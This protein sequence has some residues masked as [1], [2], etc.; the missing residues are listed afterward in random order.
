[1]DLDKNYINSLMLEVYAIVEESKI[2]DINTAINI[3]KDKQIRELI[4]LER[5]AFLKFLSIKYKDKN[6][7]EEINNAKTKN[8]RKKIAEKY[9]KDYA[10]WEKRSSSLRFKIGM[11]LST[12]TFMIVGA[13]NN[14]VGLVAILFFCNELQVIFHKEKMTMYDD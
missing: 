13:T 14:L 11:G 2:P 1:V 12:V 8:E 5:K 4:K 9:A 10:K 3:F 6:I 7:P